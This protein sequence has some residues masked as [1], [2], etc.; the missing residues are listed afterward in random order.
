MKD[1]TLRI[2]I[3]IRIINATFYSNDTQNDTLAPIECQIIR[4]N[5]V[6]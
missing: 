3:E 2:C 5:E 6:K 4:L 1:T